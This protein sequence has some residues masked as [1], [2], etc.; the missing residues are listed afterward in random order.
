ML[1]DSLLH[2]PGIVVQ[3]NARV[4]PTS[5]GDKSTVH[6]RGTEGHENFLKHRQESHF[7]RVSL[8]SDK[9]KRRAA[10]TATRGGA[11]WTALNQLRSGGGNTPELKPES[12]AGCGKLAPE[13]AAKKKERNGCVETSK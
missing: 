11:A 12:K 7:L 4:A 10:F 3:F 13:A 8:G 2:Y 5:H 1:H 6:F 9:P